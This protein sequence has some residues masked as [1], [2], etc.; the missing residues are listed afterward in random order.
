[1]EHADGVED[2]TLK[3]L[4]LP[5]TRREAIQ[6]VL[7]SWGVCL[8][9]DGGSALR[10]FQQDSTAAEIIPKDRTFTGAAVDT[11]AVV[12]KVS[13]TAHTYTVDSGGSVQV[14]GVDVYK[15]QILTL[16]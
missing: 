12:T 13:V 9:T 16:C 14:G 8:A 11:A 4:L 7:F 2:V 5:Q 10:V 15:R 1:M 3:G 6:Q